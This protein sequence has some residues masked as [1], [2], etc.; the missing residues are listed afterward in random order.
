VLFVGH[1]STEKRLD[2][3][4]EAWRDLLEEGYHSRLI[5]IG[6]T[7]GF[8]VNP[9]LISSI[10]EDGRKRRVLEK[11]TLIESTNSVAEYMKA[12]DIFAHPSIR[13]GMPNVV[14]EAMACSLP[15]ITTEIPGV[16]DFIINNGTTG[17]LIKQDDSI[18]FKNKL[19]TLLIDQG[20]GDQIGKNARDF[21]LNR[22]DWR[23]VSSAIMNAYEMASEG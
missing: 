5:V 15:C 12:A 2:V 14:L 21:I 3:L 23:S 13:E 9:A 19:R 16:T 10:L 7:S 8:E 1:L 4:Y 11:L 6:R 18:G 22:H 20:F 17:F